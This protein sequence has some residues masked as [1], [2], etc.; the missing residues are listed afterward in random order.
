MSN[1]RKISSLWTA[2]HKRQKTGFLGKTKFYGWPCSWGQYDMTNVI[3]FLLLLKLRYNWMFISPSHN[4]LAKYCYYKNK[5]NEV[6]RLPGNIYW[7]SLHGFHSQNGAAT[8]ASLH[9]L[10]IDQESNVSEQ[11]RTW[12][13]Y[14][15]W[16]ACYYVCSPFQKLNHYS[17][18][19]MLSFFLLLF[20]FSNPQPP[21]LKLRS[22]N[23]ARIRCSSVC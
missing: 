14:S 13:L 6:L 22:T 12:I 21:A 16:L 11:C 23:S 18:I 1:K 2:K 15:S 10:R 20:V 3:V 7:L 4:V 17:V 19:N 8:A 5:R 9:K